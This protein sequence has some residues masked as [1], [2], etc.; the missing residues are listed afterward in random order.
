MK[1]IA[2]DRLIR[3]NKK[4][5]QYALF[6]GV[7]VLAGG[8]YLSTRNTSTMVTLSYVA[9]LGGI[10]LS[11]VGIYFSNRWGRNPRPDELLTANLK[12]LDDRYTFFNYS[13]PV[14]FLLLGP[15]GVWILLPY[16]QGGRITFEKDRW[17]QK[18]GNWYLKIFAQEGLGRPDLEVTSQENDVKRRLGKTLSEDQIPTIKPV[19][20]MTNPK[21]VIDVEDAPVPTI[22]VKKL[23][24]TVRKKSKDDNLP[25]SEL[26]ELEKALMG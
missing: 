25:D 8:L 11:Q 16:H 7:I 6:G 23:K 26:T 20:V 5:G 15:S 3:R 18:G 4:I 14:P 12:G 24:D 13:S 22:P 19:I 17:K 1:I 2:N 21:T 9:L 10:I